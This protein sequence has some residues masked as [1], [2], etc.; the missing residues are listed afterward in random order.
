MLAFVCT[1]LVITLKFVNDPFISDNFVFSSKILLGVYLLWVIKIHFLTE[2]PLMSYL[3]VQDLFIWEST[4]A[5]S[6]VEYLSCEGKPKSY[7]NPNRQAQTF[8]EAGNLNDRQLDTYSELSWHIIYVK[9]SC[10]TIFFMFRTL[11]YVL[12]CRTFCFQYSLQHTIINQS[13]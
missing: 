12:A 4:S 5:R 13:T 7:C 2:H 1:Y 9:Q 8:P 11:H 10:T 3:L 6:S